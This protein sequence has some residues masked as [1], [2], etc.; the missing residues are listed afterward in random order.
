MALHVPVSEP[1]F[2]WFIKIWKDPL[3][4]R[5]VH[6]FFFFSSIL[7]LV[8][9]NV[10]RRI[11]LS[12][13][14]FE[15]HEGVYPLDCYRLPFIAQVDEFKGQSPN[16]AAVNFGS[17]EKRQSHSSVLTLRREVCHVLGRGEHNLVGDKVLVL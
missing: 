13:Y 15:V 8:L 3:Q 17:V 10:G 4:D 2:D 12:I 7:E 11:A 6:L 16:E 5:N 1:F 9:S 14:E